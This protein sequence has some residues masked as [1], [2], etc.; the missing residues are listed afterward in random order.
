MRGKKEAIQPTLSNQQVV[1]ISGGMERRRKA[2]KIT[3]ANSVA[4][5]KK[6]L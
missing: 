5:K 3:L 6:L 2:G 4:G 1:L